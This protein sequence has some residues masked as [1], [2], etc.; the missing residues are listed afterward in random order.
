MRQGRVAKNPPKPTG[1]VP[2]YK[3]ELEGKSNRVLR[4][5]NHASAAPKD[6][7]Y[8][9]WH[10]IN[11]IKISESGSTKVLFIETEGGSVVLKITGEMGLDYFMN[12]LGKCIGVPIP[13]MRVLRYDEKEFS[14]MVRL[15]RETAYTDEVLI[16]RVYP[17]FNVAF[18]E[19]MDYVPSLSLPYLGTKR[20]GKA[21]SV[22]DDASKE[23]LHRLGIT[24][25]F[26]VFINNGDRYPLPMWRNE[27]NVE[28]L[29][30]GFEVTPNVT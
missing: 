19:I 12:L 7:K 29:L 30:L 24:L 8:V 10:E 23:R 15:I 4:E 28:N 6:L 17:K 9:P 14:D 20:V 11:A 21:F 25:A 3:S 13:S 16:H 2:Q 5:F 27:G 22:N 26:D 18:I 1:F